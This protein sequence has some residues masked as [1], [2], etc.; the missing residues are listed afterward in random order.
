MSLTQK[1]QN[2]FAGV[3]FAEAGEHET[4][5]EIAGLEVPEKLESTASLEKLNTVFAAAALA[6]EGCRKEALEMLSPR[7]STSFLEQ[8]GLAGVRVWRGSVPAGGE[9]FAEIVGLKGVR[10]RV[11]TIPI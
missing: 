5:L 4:A 10:V 3:A 11:L 1:L 7:R 6:E 8:I 2:W 9:S